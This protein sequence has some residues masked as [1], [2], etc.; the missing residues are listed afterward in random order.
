MSPLLDVGVCLPTPLFLLSSELFSTFPTTCTN[1][2]LPFW[3]GKGSSV[4]GCR[5]FPAPPQPALGAEAKAGA[6][7]SLGDS[8]WG[9]GA[10]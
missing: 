1:H 6:T 7:Q 5:P 4:L 9:E 10:P 2:G 3:A 8:G